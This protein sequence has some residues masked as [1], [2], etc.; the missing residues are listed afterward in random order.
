MRNRSLSLLVALSLSLSAA[1]PLFA[2]SRD[3]EPRDPITRLVR[4]IK[5]TL[6]IGTNNDQIIVPHP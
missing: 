6:H 2:I 3:F 5:K 1:T 4:L